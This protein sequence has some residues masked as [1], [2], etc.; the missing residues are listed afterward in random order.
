VE[1]W[2]QRNL[3]SHF[4]RNFVD[5]TTQLVL[6][7]EPC[8][9]SLLSYLTY[10]QSCEGLRAITEFDGGSQQDVFTGGSQQICE[11]LAAT[12]GPRVVLRA[13]VRAVEQ[14]GD[15]VTI[16]SDAGLVRAARAIVA[17]SP[18]LVASIDFS[19]ALSPR[20]AALQERMPMGGY[21]KCVAV[22]EEPWWRREG[23]AGIGHSTTGPLQMVVDGGG[24]DSPQGTLVGYATAA[25]AGECRRMPAGERRDHLL[26]AM[27]RIFGARAGRPRV[28]SELDWSDEPWSGG[29]PVGIMQPGTLTTAGPA[30]REPE[31]RVHWAGSD[32]ALEFAGYMEGGLEAAE[33]AAGEVRALLSSGAGARSAGSPSSALAA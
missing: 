20:R 17:L 27:Q 6:G 31:G 19:P 4:A 18:A 21:M 26:G 30:L 10:L 11:R 22:Y 1:E 25:A 13:P 5:F 33:R 23:L 28:Y 8:E 12:L 2:K 9:L 32:T 24:A 15:G 16:R 3:R 7:V 14:D 29:C